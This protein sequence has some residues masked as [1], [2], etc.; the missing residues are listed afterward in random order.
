MDVKKSIGWSAIWKK[1]D[2]LSVWTGFLIL[3]VFIAGFTLKL[4]DWKWMTGAEFGRKSGAWTEKLQTLAGDAEAGGEAALKE[5]LAALGSAL[6]TK[7]RVSAGD[8]AATL[9][10][11]AKDAQEPD[12]TKR[13]DAL[14]AEIRTAAGQTVARVF[15]WANLRGALLVLAG[16]W[17]LA[18]LAIG[19]M[20]ENL[21]GFLVGFPVIFVLTTLSF[22]IAGNN[23]ITYY[24]IEYVIWA[25]LIGLF[26]SNVIGVPAWLKAAAKTELYI[27]IGLVLLGAE[28]LFSTILKAGALAMIQAVFVIGAV[29]YVCYWLAKRFGLDKEFG[30]IL[31]T[32][33]SVC[34]VSAAIAA[35]GALKGDPKKVSHTISLVLLVAIPMLIL[36][37]I[38]ARAL[39]MPLS[40]AGAWIGGTIDTTGAVAAAGSIAGP[41]AL[42]VA[43]VVKLAQNIF[44]GL[45]AFLLAIWAA[46][47]RKGAGAERP[48]AVE[49][50]NRFPTFGL[51]F[52]VASL[53]FSL[54]LSEPS[55]KVVTKLTSGL[56]GFWFALAFLSIGLDTRFKDLIA[57]GGGKPALTFILA[58][59]FNI[60]WTLLLAYLLFGGLIFPSPSF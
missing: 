47:D 49:I 36:Q 35:G 30:A 57:M 37:P 29:W 24:G 22:F 32:G 11:A 16:F 33:V 43:T 17:V 41:Q 38:I 48:G 26:I 8:A 2:W 50:W 1:D 54:L 56:R 42:S 44:I 18:A 55:A 52:I 39:Q 7:D 12:L 46:F 31:A 45:I 28:V 20:G 9:Q 60:F 27:K 5:P 51:G 14:G 3:G 4:P 19:L 40:V 21:G 23:T 6:S 59:V 53:A 25:L 10:T 15:S 34:G 13:A 58:Q